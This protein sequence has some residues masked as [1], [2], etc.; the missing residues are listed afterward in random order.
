MYESRQCYFCY[1]EVREGQSRFSS[2]FDAY[3]HPECCD[4][5][6]ERG[7]PEALLI[8]EEGEG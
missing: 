2:E 8:K 3:Y 5:A 4:I 1:S 7:D 6:A